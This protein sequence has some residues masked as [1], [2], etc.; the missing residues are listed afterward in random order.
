MWSSVHADRIVFPR[1]FAP[2]ESPVADM[3]KPDREAL[4]LNG[5]W[6]FQPQT[7]P[8]GYQMSAGHP[9]D[10][11]PPTDDR[12]EKTPIRVPSPWNVNSF[13][14]SDGKGPDFQCY[15]SYPASWNSVTMGWLRRTFHVPGSW[16][17]KRIILHFDAV[18]GRTQVWVN[19]KLIGG[20]FDLFLP[21]EFDITDRIKPGADNELLVGV[22]K[23]SLFAVKSPAGR[24]T[25]QGGS[26]WGD[27]VTGIWQDVY[28]EAVPA[29]RIENVFMKPEVDQDRLGADVTLKNDS[30]TAVTLH[31]RGTI[32]S[33]RNEARSDLLFAPEPKWSLDG[34]DALQFPDKS[35][36]VPAH[37]ESTVSLSQP[38]RGR[39]ALW[40]PENPN[41][42][43]L[44]LSLG[45]IP[46]QNFDVMYTRFG[47]RQFTLAKK[48]AFLNGKPIVFKGDACHFIGIPEM[49]RRY[50]WAW[51]KVL[52]AANGNT[53]RL[54]AEPYP[55]YFLDEADEM[56]VCIL[57]ESAIWGSG[58]APK[59]DSPDFW[60]DAARHIR[61]LVLRDRN[62]PSIMGWSIANEVYAE[63]QG[64][65]HSAPPLVEAVKKNYAILR[66]IC[67]TNDP[68]RAWIS[69]DGDHDGVGT[70]PVFS[71]HYIGQ[72]WADQLTR[73][74]LPWGDGENGSA[75]FA[76]PEQVS[77][78]NGQRA[79][80]SMEGRMEVL[81]REA[82]SIL[83][84]QSHY[85]GIYHCIFNL[86]WHGLQPLPLGLADPTRSPTLADGIFFQPYVENKFGVQPERIGP[87][88]TTLNPG[89]DPRLPLYKPWPLFEAIRDGFADSTAVSKWDLPFA[90]PPAPTP[91]P[92]AG[93]PVNGIEVLGGPNS[94]LKAHLE[95]QGV[96]FDAKSNPQLI[97]VDGS[98]PPD[99]TAK[100]RMG[101]CLSGGGSVF[102][103][104]AT[105]QA[106]PTLNAL[107]PAPLEI[108]SRT[109]TSLLQ[110]GDDPLIAGIKPSDLYFSNL[111]PSNILE[112]G[113]AGPL[114]ARGRIL[115]EA[116]NTDSSLWKTEGEITKDAEIFRSEQ[117]TK[118]GGVALASIPEGPGRLILCNIPCSSSI[119]KRA[120]LIH[121]LLVNLG[122]TLKPESLA[123]VALNEDGQLIQ[124]LW[125]TGF[126]G[127]SPQAA[128]SA[129]F[130]NP[131]AGAPIRAGAA[132][133]PG[134]K[135]EPLSA[136]GTLFDL[137]RLH[138]KSLRENVVSYFSFWVFSP[139][140]MNDLLADPHLP[141]VDFSIESTDTMKVWLNGQIILQQVNKRG[142]GAG[143]PLKKGW[144]HFLIEDFHENGPWHFSAGLNSTQPTFFD[145]INTA[146]EKPAGD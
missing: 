9:P 112:G 100:V 129:T 36:S 86:A 31:L 37:G 59:L 60:S 107:L 136:F 68:T 108:T 117:E 127:T 91:T 61:D 44:V 65:H 99:A 54:H 47:W 79:Y 38:V 132:A 125:C 28:L 71:I 51:Y 19:G 121:A 52:K 55:A 75:Y 48:Q 88:C 35:V 21:F 115:L 50:A 3:E 97:F 134:I 66:D 62:H 56:G 78:F 67:R 27:V 30:D 92:R 104:D 4:C 142:G 114:I 105:P 118:P 101:A 143:L 72:D 146:L 82:F 29:V 15:P 84:F 42:Y 141:K 126:P 113:L 123:S 140:A 103:W 145:V 69:A 130:V 111:E 34:K 63:V 74:T 58:G 109:S 32:H 20:H 83:K 64:I 122:V 5:T 90:A 128:L 12:W 11:T 87:Y 119:P 45:N 1:D 70:L 73:G 57:D 39:L 124:A 80:E 110:T 46:G 41:L 81:A 135:W 131:K 43:G 2:T 8:E 137:R 138:L 144:N 93:K 25:F 7:L 85:D 120:A 18:A 95:R 76:N 53:V 102:I 96:T 116:C 13:A 24:N 23:G 26:M 77:K 40:S 106:L 6:Q 22:Q 10:L 133:A 16:T 14:N 94:R 17:G 89:Y 139:N 49:T 33:W 98:M